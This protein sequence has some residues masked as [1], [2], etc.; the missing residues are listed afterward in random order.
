MH[1]TRLRING[2]KHSPFANDNTV[3]ESIVV[4]ID[5]VAVMLKRLS[6]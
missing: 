3:L 4:D 2:S 1:F 6:L 5:E